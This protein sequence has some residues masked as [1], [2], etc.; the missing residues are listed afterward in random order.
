MPPVG[1]QGGKEEEKMRTKEIWK[2]YAV[3]FHVLLPL[4]LA[5]K[6]YELSEKMEITYSEIIRKAL[7]EYF[8]KLE[9]EQGN[10][11]ARDS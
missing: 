4:P 3:E 1:V 10:E 6:L 9:K 5:E 8:E 11:H 7:K 2:R